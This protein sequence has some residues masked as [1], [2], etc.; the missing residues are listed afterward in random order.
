MLYATYNMKLCLLPQTPLLCPN[1]W[2]TY[3]FTFTDH[4]NGD[5]WSTD[6]TVLNTKPGRLNETVD[7]LTEVER[8]RPEKSYNVT[9]TIATDLGNIT[10]SAIFGK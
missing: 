2:A 5:S 7:I 10:S 6:S 4:E 3:T 1:Q 9:V 8:F